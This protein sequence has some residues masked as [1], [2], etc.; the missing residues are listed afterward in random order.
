MEDLDEI[1]RLIDLEKEV[2]DLYDSHARKVYEGI[3]DMGERAFLVN[4]PLYKY[5]DSDLIDT[6]IEHFTETEEYEKCSEL[7]EV[8][9]RLKGI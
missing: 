3:I 4:G 1:M 7:Q 8:S 5:K 9:W 6:L 2:N